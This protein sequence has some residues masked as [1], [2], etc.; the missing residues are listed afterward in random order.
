MRENMGFLIVSEGGDGLGLAM[1]LQEE[2][3]LVSMTI[4]DPIAEQRGE[5]L[6]EKNSKPDF[7]PILVADCTGSGSLLDA[8]RANEGFAFGGSQ[9]MDRLESDRKYSSQVFKDCGIKEPDSKS[10]SNWDKAFEFIDSV[11]NKLVFKPEGKYSGVVPSYVPHDNEELVEMLNHYKGIIGD[12]PEFTLQEFVEGACISSEAWV[13][14][15]KLLTPFNHTLERKQLM[16]GDLG[17][18][19]GCTGNV[20]WVCTEDSCPL[21]DNL[22][23]LEAFLSSCEYTGC[24]DI[25]TVVSKEGEV[26]ALEF[27]PR[28]GYD[29]FPTYLYG[30]FEGN[31][32]EFIYESCRGNIPELSLKT[33]FAAGIRISIPPWPSEDFHA[34]GSLPI[35]GLRK[36]DFDRFYS[37]EVGIQND[38]LVTSGGYGII[39]VAVG[40]GETIEIAFEEA[41]KVANKIRIP[42]KQYRS[43]FTEVFTKELR[44]IARSL[45]VAEVNT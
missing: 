8:Y 4:K 12:E 29:A 23:A 31:F 14:K 35:R 22:H 39:G 38:S 33:G 7:K 32:G 15:G 2:G 44:Q 42:D 17:P 27:T 18:S 6:I 43:D 11:E 45:S 37:Y 34:R 28:F 25:N 1:R 9:I 21:C 13:A 26:F 16:D 30:L 20:I 24:I 19:G 36:S 5:G 40:Q 10:F 3:H 41:Y